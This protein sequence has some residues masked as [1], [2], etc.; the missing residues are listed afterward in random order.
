MKQSRNPTI[1]TSYYKR[2][3]TKTCPE[4]GYPMINVEHKWKGLKKKVA[5]FPRAWYCANQD[6]YFSTGFYG[7]ENPKNS[8]NQSFTAKSDYQK[9]HGNP[10][11]RRR[12]MN[13]RMPKKGKP[14]WVLGRVPEI[15]YEPY[16]SSQHKGTTF[17]HKFGDTGSRVLPHKPLLVTDGVDIWFAHEK[18]STLHVNERGIIG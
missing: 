13:I 15:R 6:K 5:R 11:Q 8:T 1:D 10:P 12:K 4:C 3:R 18:G 16:G 17:R 2:V 7:D 14:L 9:F